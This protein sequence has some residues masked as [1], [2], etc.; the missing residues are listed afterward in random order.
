MVVRC[1]NRAV[2]RNL[3]II[4]EAINRILTKDPDIKTGQPHQN[5]KK[6]LWMDA[7]KFL[8]VDA[9][10]GNHNLCALLPFY[11]RV[12]CPAGNPAG[13]ASHTTVRTGRVYSG[14]LRYGVIES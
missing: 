9:L 3:E 12:D 14:S 7:S 2:E 13:R 4:G 11:Y 8:I 5:D 1:S 6:L 10:T